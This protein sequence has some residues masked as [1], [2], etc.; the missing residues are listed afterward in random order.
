MIRRRGIRHVRAP[1]AGGACGPLWPPTRIPGCVGWF[2]M[3]ETFT[4]DAGTVTSIRNMVSGSDD[5]AEGTN[6]PAL[7][8]I[9]G[10]PAM[11]G[12]GTNDILI[13]TEAAVVAAANQAE[14]SFTLTIVYQPAATVVAGTQ[15]LCAWG[16]SGTANTRTAGFVHNA[17]GQIQLSCLSDGGF[18]HAAVGVER[19]ATDLRPKVVTAVCSPQFCMQYANRTMLQPGAWF[20][21]GFNGQLTPDRFALLARPDSAPDRFSAERLGC[22]IIHDHPL[23]PAEVIGLHT[24]LMGKWGIQ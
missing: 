17:A 16:N 15:Q 12:D 20:G 23:A 4:E 18:V 24:A 21:T 1:D 2:D 6:P 7:S 14:R 8:L 10:R 22:I 9:N 11:L 5:M 19:I 13:S 3:L